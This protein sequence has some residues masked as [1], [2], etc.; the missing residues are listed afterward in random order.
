M[1]KST[2]GTLTSHDYIKG[3]IL[4]LITSILTTS[5][6]LLTAW[7]TSGSVPT[8]ANLIL[9][10]VTAAATFIGYLIKNINTNSQGQFATPEPK[11]IIPPK[12]GSL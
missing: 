7:A 3:L 10:P 1:I 6:T 9:I 12:T 11:D 2:R 5:Y 4:T 8:K